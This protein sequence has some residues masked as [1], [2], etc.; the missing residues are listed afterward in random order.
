LA[1]R[2]S[3]VGEGAVVVQSRQAE[4]LPQ[5]L[6]VAV[7]PLGDLLAPDLVHAGVEAVAPAGVVGAAGHEQGLGPLVVAALVEQGPGG[8]G[9]LVV[10]E[11]EARDDEAGVEHGA[12]GGVGAGP[13]RAER[14]GR[15]VEAEQV[16]DEQVDGRDGQHD[17]Q[18]RGQAD[19]HDEH[20]LAGLVGRHEQRGHPREAVPDEQGQEQDQGGAAEQG[21][22]DAVDG[23]EADLAALE[24]RPH[25]GARLLVVEGHVGG[26]VG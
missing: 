7:G 10:V 22:P 3:V 11:A 20:P 6:V 5:P 17:R 8:R 25:R 13:G 19:A 16:A 23:G 9:E 21:L 12:T 14:V 26:S 4:R 2:A 24:E 1:N 15:E 18:H